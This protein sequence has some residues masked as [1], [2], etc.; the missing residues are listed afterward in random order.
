MFGNWPKLTIARIWGIPVRVDATFALVPFIFLRGL[1]TEAMAAHWPLLT[2]VI[3][4]VFLSVLLHELGHALTAKAQRVGVDEVVVGGFYG[5]ASI[6]QRGAARG[7]LIRILAAGP[8]ANLAIFAV[9]WL[10]LSM[11]SLAELAP[12]GLALS[13]GAADSWP[14]AAARML[15]LVNLAMFVF[16]LL[17]AFPLDGGRILGHLLDAVMSMVASAR[18]VS[19]LGIA[20]GVALV[21]LGFGFGLGIVLTIVGMLVVM[22]NLSRLNRIRQARSAGRG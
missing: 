3:V 18:I 10:A 1:S 15:A 8:L 5:Y 12:R 11:P 19:G 20:L 17:P 6:R 21:L 2:A 7:S 14:E 4:G 22:T 16:N 13:R 9:L